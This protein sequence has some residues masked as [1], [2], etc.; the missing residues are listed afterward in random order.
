MRCNDSYYYFEKNIFGDVI[1]AYNASGI[2]VAEFRYDSYGNIVSASGSMADKVKIR[3]RGYY[4]DEETG[5][6]YLQSRYY[7]PSLCRFI[8]ADQYEL[9]GTLSRT[10][11]QLNLY[12]YCNNNPIMYTDES[13]ESFIISLLVAIGVGMALGG[14]TGAIGAWMTGQNIVGGIISGALIGG[15]LGA[16]MIFGGA[17]ALTIGGKVV[18]GFATTALIANKCLLLTTMVSGTAAV[19]FGAGIG[20]YAIEQYANGREFT[21]NGAV[22][23]GINTA[24]KGL[25]AFGIGMAMAAGGG[26]NY[27]LEG[28]KLTFKQKIIGGIGRG[29]VSNIIKVVDTP[30]FWAY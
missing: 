12:A 28:A 1:R 11:G 24:I 5:F 2:A 27:I 9:L 14:G 13:G 17:T 18:E 29:I 26:Y 20:A 19:S 16:A 30:W 3:Y 15:V 6:Y 23:S 10:P 25:T 8:S 4:W 7:D 22:Y 21:W